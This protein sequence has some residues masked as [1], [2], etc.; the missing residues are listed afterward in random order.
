[1]IAFTYQVVIFTFRQYQK[2]LSLSRYQVMIKHKGEP[3]KKAYGLMN[4]LVM[5][6]PLEKKEP[7]AYF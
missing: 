2:N 1:M 5:H 3:G 6:T 4:Q 7:N